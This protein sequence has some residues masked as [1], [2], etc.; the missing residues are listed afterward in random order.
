MREMKDI[1]ETEN[2]IGVYVLIS[3]AI[4]YYFQIDPK[5]LNF[6]ITSPTNL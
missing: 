6:I 5:V 4:C 1:Y 3:P 2:I